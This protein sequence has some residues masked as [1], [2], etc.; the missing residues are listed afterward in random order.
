MLMPNGE[1]KHENVH[2]T[3][4]LHEGYDNKILDLIRHLDNNL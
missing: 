3:T 4:C 2:G 1:T